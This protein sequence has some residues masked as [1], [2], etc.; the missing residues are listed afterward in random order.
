MIQQ[1]IKQLPVWVIAALLLLGFSASAQV[2]NNYANAG[3]MPAP[4][5]ASLGK[6]TDIPVNYFT[7]IPQ[8]K[9]PIYTIEEG[10]ISLPISV[11][12]H[13]SGVKPNEPASWVGTNWSLNAG[14]MVTRTIVGLRDELPSGYI[15]VI[16][17]LTGNPK[18][19]IE[20]NGNTIPDTEPDIFSYNFNGYTGKFFIGNRDNTPEVVF[21]EKTDIK[22]FIDLSSAAVPEILGFVFVTP[23]GNRYFFGKTT[24]NNVDA[25]ERAIPFE[26]TPNGD[27][28]YTSWY[29]NT[30]QTFDEKFFINFEYEK[31]NSSYQLAYPCYYHFNKKACDDGDSFSVPSTPAVDCGGVNSAEYL[32]KY[33]YSQR[34]KSIKTST[35]LVQVDFVA[36]S[37]P[38]KDLGK[39][40]DSTQKQA[41]ALDKIKVSFGDGT[42][43]CKEWQF[44]YTYFYD[45]RPEVDTWITYDPDALESRFHLKLDKIQEQTCNT[46]NQII[47]PPT[48][49]EYDGQSVSYT[50]NGQTVNT[51]F[52]PFFLTKE[53]D[54]WGFYNGQIGNQQAF[55]PNVP[56]TTVNAGGVTYT[57]GSSNRETNATV[58]KSGSLK[59]ITYPTG[60]YTSYEFEP[61]VVKTEWNNN[62]SNN[63][64]SLSTC[65]TSTCCNTNSAE[66]SITLTEDMI[67]NGKVYLKISEF[68]STTIP[69]CITNTPTF[70]AT[71]NLQIFENNATTA[72]KSISFNI[73]C[74]SSNGEVDSAAISMKL[75][76]IANFSPGTIYKF[77][78][79][80]TNGLSTFRVTLPTNFSNK[81][82]GGLRVKKITTHDA[83]NSANNITRTYNY[84]ENSN[85]NVSSGRLYRVPDYGY[86]FY[87]KYGIGTPNNPA[88]DSCAFTI[89][90][91]ASNTHN[92]LTNYQ[93]YHIGYQKVTEI[94][95][96]VSSENGKKI[97][98]YNTETGNIKDLS[99]L[100]AP[101]LPTIKNGTP[102]ADSVFTATGQIISYSNTIYDN[103]IHIQNYPKLSYKWQR[104]EVNI[105]GGGTQ[106]YDYIYNTDFIPLRTTFK[107]V[108]KV[109]SYMDGVVTTTTLD[110]N[111]T[112][113]P[114]QIGER[115]IQPRYI[116]TTNS[117]GKTY[118]TEQKFAYDYNII[119]S[120]K[121]RLLQYNMIGLPYEINQYVNDV[122]VSGTRT[123]YQLVTSSTS[124]YPSTY[125]WST[126]GTLPYPRF[127]QNYEIGF[128]SNGSPT[129]TGSWVNQVEVETYYTNGLPKSRKTAGWAD[130]ELL[131]WSLGRLI[132][133]TFKNY[134][135]TY[136]YHSGTPLVATTTDIDGQKTWYD[137][138][139]LM[140]LKLAS[141]RPTTANDKSTA[142]VTTEYQYK[143]M[144]A[145]TPRNYVRSITTFGAVNGS[146]LSIVEN[147]QYMDGLGRQV[148]SLSKKASPLGSQF[149]LFEVTT[150]DNQGRLARQ[151]TPYTAN[152]QTGNF[153]SNPNLAVIPFTQYGYEASPLNRPVSVTP[154]GWFA[155][156]TSYG[157]NTTGS[158]STFDNVISNLSNNTQYA[159]GQLYKKTVTDPNNN[160]TIVFTDKQGRVVLTR[161]ANQTGSSAADTY[162]VYDDKSRVTTVVPPGATISETNSVF[163]YTYDPSD[164]ILTKKA[165]GKGLETMRYDDRDLMTFYQDNVMSTTPRWIMTKYNAYGQPTST[166]FWNGTTPTANNSNVAYNELLT[167]TT[168]D[169]A[170]AI[171]RG[172][173]KQTKVKILD[174]ATTP[175]WLEN[176]YTYDNH[177]RPATITGNNHIN[178]SAGSE[179]LTFN[180]Y[181]WADNL[182]ESTRA[183]KK[184]AA[185]TLTIKDRYTFD[186]RGRQ[187]NYYHKINT[188][189]E[190][191]VSNQKYN[192]RNFMVQKNLHGTA[193]GGFLQNVDYTYNQQGWI[194]GINGMCLSGSSSAMATAPPASAKNFQINAVF[195]PGFTNPETPNEKKWF[196][197][198][199]SSTV[200][201]D[202]V[203]KDLTQIDYYGLKS[204][205][206]DSVKWEK[207]NLIPTLTGLEITISPDLSEFKAET[208]SDLSAFF[209]EM[210]KT[211]KE[212]MNTQGVNGVQFEEVF[213]QIQSVVEQ[214]ITPV[215][216]AAASVSM[217]AS[218]TVPT[219]SDLFSMGLFYETANTTL[220][221][222]SQK[223]GNVSHMWSQVA[224]NNPQYYG[225]QYDYLNRL[226]TANNAEFNTGTSAYINL[227]RYNEVNTYDAR[228][229]ILTTN[230]RGLTATNTFGVIDNLTFTYVS[231]N[232]NR[233]N[234]IS[235]SGSYTRGF[236]TTTAVQL[237]TYDNNG[238]MSRDNHKKITTAYYYHNMVK[239]VT[240]DN[241]NTIN[242]LYDASGTKLSKTTNASGNNVT[243]Y[244]GG[245]EYKGTATS[246]AIEAIYH[247]EG[248]CTPQSGNTWRYEYSLR[249]HLGNTRV[250]FADLDNSGT[251]T[252]SEIL[253]QN[254]YY[255]F[256]ANIEG[257]S[258]ASTPNKYQYNGKEWNEDF[259]LNWNDYGA[260]M[261][262]PWV[263]RWWGVDNKC[264]KREIFTPYN[265]VQ[266]NPILRI[267]PNGY[268]DT[269]PDGRYI[270]EMTELEK[271]MYYGKPNE[272]EIEEMSRVLS[273]SQSGLPSEI[274]LTWSERLYL[275]GHLVGFTLPSTKL[276]AAKS[277]A[278]ILDGL[279]DIEKTVVKDAKKILDSKTFKTAVE[280][281]KTGSTTETTINGYK[282]IFQSDGPFSG[283]TLFGEKGFVI[284]KEA[285]ASS[286]ELSKTVYHE[287]FRLATSTAKTNGFV[288]QSVITTET[289][290]TTDFIEKVVNAGII[291]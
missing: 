113:P 32:Y 53:V 118:K 116:T 210:E 81:T 152:S 228:G 262:D 280:N 198:E 41:K 196:S 92:S 212:A 188:G 164:N 120:V 17:S 155:T 211:T 2:E 264:E 153:V 201:V 165:P 148:Q 240:F 1:Y 106:P 158:G 129:G 150:Y 104:F 249:D 64:I 138:D 20:N 248:R 197:T 170:T 181:D 43:F 49:F 109:T 39:G 169:D 266:D 282:I 34:L 44:S 269:L 289:K 234:S 22:G 45:N 6:Y 193:A 70:Q 151:Y 223:N 67:S 218:A 42:T 24:L 79:T 122:Q 191:L 52:V 250:T 209:L 21:I 159:A 124:A 85:T 126:S 144:D 204:I 231:T 260:R 194:S 160:K 65:A 278:N 134:S 107:R 10:G 136:E 161:R 179:T 63:I 13:A 157:T 29:L 119:G 105:D 31:E 271:D 184:D 125:S 166:G 102:F 72:F 257:L 38:R 87:K 245:I 202:G 47:L 8:I 259:G 73:T 40:T 172:R 56:P 230:R 91:I 77:K 23:D 128:G 54:H 30:I 51:Q 214:Q 82:V 15:N 178:L 75:W 285:L 50:E 61:N 173:I 200:T 273:L 199:V 182:L 208:E 5:A 98:R 244:I 4:N 110:Y 139:A 71:Y 11:S 222:T 36:S 101:D 140:R 9:L 215:S 233:V 115:R 48:I 192:D 225:F 207:T 146:N 149:D 123:E 132:K 243:H 237:Y 69:S 270:W 83:V 145:T 97:F 114:G 33:V 168:Y 96:N 74:S 229:N 216:A 241:G 100:G 68:L 3:D 131:E 66:Q 130:S 251:V 290:M 291:K 253:Q 156:T 185:S 59:K 27:A 252:T 117:D 232:K 246:F 60:G 287:T 189:A 258:S 127:I 112:P 242:W 239:T 108:G 268:L 227:N 137:Y 206:T 186:H 174:G 90:R 255:P 84:D 16:N 86:G 220:G 58:I 288:S 28:Y 281:M 162:N 205:G 277:G 221:A 275:L 154:P 94:S 135:K 256:G 175:K 177:G 263:G 163:A 62:Q 19:D 272:T 95:G 187:V 143:Y 88:F 103:A 283:F 195:S 46:S 12:Y 284:G 265:Y 254:H 57:Y 238:N 142:K 37:T 89:V 171:F 26:Q 217:T 76:E 7:G 25:R 167:E 267:D 190:V 141:V 99:V 55:T 121:T 286:T 203:T 261:Y 133:S 176:N 235:E 276:V 93:G 279:S 80:S 18:T 147:T 183:H 224:C 247:A 219:S 226:T 14:G 111:D 180:A 78:I 213:T 274:S 35:G 236:K